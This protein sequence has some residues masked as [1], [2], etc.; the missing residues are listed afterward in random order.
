MKYCPICRREY[1]DSDSSCVE[2]GVLKAGDSQSAAQCEL[3]GRIV[4]RG[5]VAC[6]NCGAK[7]NVRGWAGDS[8]ARSSGM[9]SEEKPPS[10]AQW[11]DSD[12]EDPPPEK[13][14]F[15]R[16]GDSRPTV[17]PVKRTGVVL[18]V[19]GFAA[20]IAVSL[21]VMR[22]VYDSNPAAVAPVKQPQ[23][24]P[25]TVENLLPNELPGSQ[26]KTLTDKSIDNFTNESI[27][28]EVLPAEPP[29]K[30]AES[31]GSGVKETQRRAVQADRNAQ[32]KQRVTEKSTTVSLK[33]P[34]GVRIPSP[35]EL[36]RK[37]AQHEMEQAIQNRAIPRGV[38][39]PS[40]GELRR[41]RVEH[42][43]EQAIQNRAI[44]GVNVS[45]IG[46]T[47]YLTGQVETER[48]RAAAEQAARGIP[49]V[50]NIRSSISI[51]ETKG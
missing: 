44:E 13:E 46:R 25:L 41:K 26:S 19:A 36:R 32:E 24:P 50:G 27:E 40:P 16:F 5:E 10:R 12:D 39:I 22:N 47:V 42:E 29:L 31:G 1:V 20:G 33:I 43:V 15:F 17:S 45:V 23:H 3:C 21:M 4:E 30:P 35:A 11:W 2:H 49:E 37:R 7:V 6:R 9:T 18:T 38:N 14:G 34:S 8:F 48:Q 51:R 28:T